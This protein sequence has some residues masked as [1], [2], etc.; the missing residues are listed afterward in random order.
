MTEVDVPRRVL[1]VVPRV[2]HEIR[3]IVRSIPGRHMSEAQFRVMNLLAIGINRVGKLAEYYGVSQPAMS[4]MVD[5]LV[6]IGLVG[7]ST[8]ENDRRQIDLILTKKGATQLEELRRKVRDE[9]AS[10]MSL[11]DHKKRQKLLDGLK[12]LAAV[13]RVP[14]KG[15]GR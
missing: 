4:K 2:L 1:E 3:A 9:V 15:E 8:F 13:F 7:R 10:R 6:R 14:E 5:S 11:L 12:E